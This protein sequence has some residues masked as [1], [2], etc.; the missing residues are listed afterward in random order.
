LSPQ[1]EDIFKNIPDQNFADG[2]PAFGN[3]FIKRIKQTYGFT[4]KVSRPIDQV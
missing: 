3:N 1:A 4:G 2:V